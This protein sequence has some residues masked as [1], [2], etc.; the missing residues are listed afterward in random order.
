M[1][2]REIKAIAIGVSTGGFDALEA[3]LTRLPATAPPVIIAM[4]LTPGIPKLF[5]SRLN[6]LTKLTAKEAES[7][8]ILRKGH[9][10]I[11][12]G[13]QHIKVVNRPGGLAVICYSG[14]K[15]QHVLTSADVLFESVANELQENAVGV[16]LTGIGADG[17]NG[18]LKM[19]RCGALTIGQNKDSCVVYGM[20][21]IA[22][23]VGAVE[24][25]LPPAK[26]A[27][28]ILSLL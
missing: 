18:L 19:R 9:V 15:V 16:I 3:I 6:E 14:E 23:D 10:L 1:Q 13:W 7:G 5:A 12:P 21:K 8:D 20:P 4:H 22:K 17:A 2:S 28:K 25:E 24:Y 27:D 11:A 26:I